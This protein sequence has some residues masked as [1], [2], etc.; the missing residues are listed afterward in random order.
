MAGVPFC[1]GEKD[2]ELDSG[3]SCTTLH[4]VKITEVYLLHPKDFMVCE[5]YFKTLLKS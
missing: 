2:L 1:N 4:I 5:L 3:D